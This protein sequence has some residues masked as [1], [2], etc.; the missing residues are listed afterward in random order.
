M[1][2]LMSVSPCGHIRAGIAG[3]RIDLVPTFVPPES[4]RSAF[5]F[6]DAVQTATIR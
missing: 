5:E 3:P 1:A 6:A 4:S 2:G